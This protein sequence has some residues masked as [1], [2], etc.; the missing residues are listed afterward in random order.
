MMPFPPPTG[1]P[2]P[3]PLT[4]GTYDRLDYIPDPRHPDHNIPLFIWLTDDGAP[5][6][7][8]W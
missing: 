2:D 3:H 6:W 7:W 4:D 8:Q 5:Y 1:P